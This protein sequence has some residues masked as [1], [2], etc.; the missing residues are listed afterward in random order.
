[1][2]DET[3][4]FPFVAERGKLT[5]ILNKPEHCN[6]WKRK[7]R[8]II[9]IIKQRNSRPSHEF[10]SCL[11]K[12]CLVCDFY[13]IKNDICSVKHCGNIAF[14]FGVKLIIYI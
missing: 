10:D 4:Y 7:Q 3:I 13:H 6:N 8:V 14:I 9:M 12:Y 1:M 11:I 2:N 5:L